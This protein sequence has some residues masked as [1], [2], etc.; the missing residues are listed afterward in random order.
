MS[1]AARLWTRPRLCIWLT[2][3]ATRVLLGE[4]DI[5]DVLATALGYA[6]VTLVGVRLIP[7]KEPDPSLASA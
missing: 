2:E 1:C 4:H 5:S 7:N 3:P 6:G